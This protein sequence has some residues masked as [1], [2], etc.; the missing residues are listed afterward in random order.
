MLNL[1]VAGDTGVARTLRRTG[2]FSMVFN[3]VSAGELRALARSGQVSPPTAF[4]FTPGFAE[5]VPGADVAV[6]A[7]GLAG[8][9]FT[10][11]VHSF[12]AERGDR[13]NG[14]IRVTERELR[15]PELLSLLS[16]AERNAASPRPRPQSPPGPPWPPV[17]KQ[18]QRPPMPEDRPGPEPAPIGTSSPAPR[19]HG[20]VVVVAAAKGGSGRT[21]LSV[22]LAAYAAQLLRTAGRTGTVVLVDTNVQQ[23]DVA[24]YLNVRSPTILNLL[25]A[26]GALSP[27]TVRDHLARV[28]EMDLY[29]L[30]GPPDGTNADPASIDLASYPRILAVLRQ[31]FDFVFVD[32]PVAG[33][34]D[35]TLTDLIFPE[36]DAILVPV[37]PSRPTLETAHAWLKAITT[38]Q[39]PQGGGVAPQKLSVVLNRA[40]SGVDCSLEDVMAL[41]PGWR[42]AGM[43]PDDGEWTRAVNEHDLMALR[44]DP[45]LGAI[46]RDILQVV[47][48]DPVFGAVAI[49]TNGRADRRE[50]PFGSN[51]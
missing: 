34:H 24:R 31:A 13:L 40:R 6:L 22:N 8:N 38:P 4:I 20:R 18:P 29:T 36:A 37:E 42:V 35:P 48:E 21:S 32:T 41:M 3:A 30:L 25:Q 28:P 2:H 7:N 49:P 39:G 17:Q 44:C 26:P 46:F 11:L 23:A 9:G 5:D 16:I 27:E 45:K 12:F 10:V 19:R 43:I 33:F 15:I 50:G 1:V 14:N 47:T 51:L